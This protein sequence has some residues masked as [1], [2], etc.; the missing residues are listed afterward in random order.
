[1][2]NEMVRRACHAIGMDNKQPFYKYGEKHFI[3]Y[4]N[5]SVSNRLGDEYFD[6]MESEGLAESDRGKQSVTYYLT[7]KGFQWL[8]KECSMVIHAKNRLYETAYGSSE[9]KKKSHYILQR[10]I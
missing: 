7:E 5:Y 3:S 10:R 4:R 6:K 1:M 2:N 9:R 8:E